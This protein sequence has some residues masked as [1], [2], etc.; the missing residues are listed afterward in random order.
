MCDLF[1]MMD[2]INI[3]NYADENTPFVSGDTPLNLITSL[4]NA[5]YTYILN[6]FSFHACIRRF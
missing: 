1:V 4:K 2:N 3:A 5:A 6:I